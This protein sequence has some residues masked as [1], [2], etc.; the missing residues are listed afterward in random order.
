MRM[1]LRLKPAHN[2]IACKVLRL[3]HPI[4]LASLSAILFSSSLNAF[5]R[6]SRGAHFICHLKRPSL[7]C[8]FCKRINDCALVV[9]VPNIA[10]RLVMYTL[11]HQ[12]VADY[13]P[14]IIKFI[15]PSKIVHQIFQWAQLQNCPEC[16]MGRQV[17][18]VDKPNGRNCE[19]IK[20][21]NGA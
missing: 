4:F 14:E 8:R 10:M 17:G 7:S 15:E 12:C 6:S 20:T 16:N 2:M 1:K 21:S 9:Y 11:L 13:E 5:A 18:R 3:K 19:F